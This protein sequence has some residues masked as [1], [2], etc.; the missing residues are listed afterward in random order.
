MGGKDPGSGNRGLEAVAATL[1]TLHPHGRTAQ[2]EIATG[3][4][5]ARSRCPSSGYV[6]RDWGNTVPSMAVICSGGIAGE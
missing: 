2:R 1:I 4:R 3:H 6:V 5:A